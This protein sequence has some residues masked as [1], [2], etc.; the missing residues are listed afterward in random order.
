MFSVLGTQLAEFK[1]TKQIDVFDFKTGVY[2]VKAYKDDTVF[3]SKFI[4]N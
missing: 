3:T 1:N 4:K 2:L